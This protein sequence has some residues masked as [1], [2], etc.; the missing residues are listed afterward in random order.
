MMNIPRLAFLLILSALPLRAAAPAAAAKTLGFDASVMDKTAD[1]CVDF[2]QYACGGW[3]AAN[4]IPS[5]QSRWGRFQELSERNKAILRDLLEARSAPGGKRDATD[6]KIGD[7]YASCMDEAGIEAKGLSP[8]RPELDRIEAIASPAELT[9]ALARLHYSGSRAIFGF[10]SSQD[11]KDATQMIAEADQGGL[12][13]P[14]RDYYIKEDAKSAGQRRQYEEHLRRMF[15][16]LGE[17]V[18]RSS[19]SA[20]AVMAFETALARASQDLV[21]RREPKNLY[22][23]MTLDELAKL[24]PGFDWPRYLTALDAPRVR[25]LNVVAPEFLRQASVMTA[26][27]PL[28]DWKAYLRWQL[29]RAK[30]PLLPKAFVDENFDFYGKQL[31]GAKELRSRWKRC[32]D[33]TD[34]DL[35]EALGRRYVEKTFGA[36]GKKR[37]LQMVANLE[38]ALKKD[39]EGLDWMTKG[40]K[41]QAQA[42]LAAIANKI[43]YPETW[44]DYGKLAV[45]RGDALGNAERGARFEFERRLARIGKPV[46]RAEWEMTAPT[47]NAYYNPQ[48]NDINFPAG[49]LQPPFFDNAMDDAVNYGGIGAVIGH[50]LTHGFDDEGRQFDAR[51]NL[52]DWWTAADAKEFENRASCIESQYAGFTAIDDLKLNGKLTLGENAADNGGLRIAHM[53]LTETLIGKITPKRDGFTAS[54]RLFLGWGQIWCTKM[55]DEAMRMLV[56]TNPHSPGKFRVNGVMVNM[57]EFAQAFSCGEGRPM[58]S[59][60]ACRVW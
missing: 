3:L 20:R 55:T 30:A 14:D 5:D 26:S 36:K 7:Y 4:P 17:D 15:G 11:F 22:H 12:G 41:T 2:Y 16:L 23:K 48:M 25:S 31:T 29:L 60:K 28:S 39:I 27:V 34:R 44:R 38:G 52:R 43:G 6:Q 8:V 45:V 35:G 59:P 50:E 1:P 56:L 51:G 54:Q 10:G 33:L 49:I 9:E 57:P 21:A 47:V 37:M 46:D 32:V 53:A 13:L 58:V 19:A 42:K 18:E 40:T 24:A